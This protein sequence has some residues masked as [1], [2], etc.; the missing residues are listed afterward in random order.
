MVK[1]SQLISEGFLVIVWKIKLR[2]ND[3][4]GDFIRNLAVRDCV[5]EMSDESRGDDVW[6][7]APY[8]RK[9]LNRDQNEITNFRPFYKNIFRFKTSYMVFSTCENCGVNFEAFG[10][11]FHW[12]RRA[13]RHARLGLLFRAPAWELS[14]GLSGLLFSRINFGLSKNRNI[15]HVYRHLLNAI[16]PCFKI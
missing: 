14:L 9:N 11:R 4:S 15:T 3:F 8:T 6:S 7:E 10:E 13:R 5:E 16:W 1:D 2:F 12:N